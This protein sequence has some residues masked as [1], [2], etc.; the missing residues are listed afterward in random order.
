MLRDRELANWCMCKEIQ[1]V[2]RDMHAT[3]C[4]CGGIDAYGKSKH[5]PFKFKK[6]LKCEEK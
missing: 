1:G 5:R 3:C 2:A 6:I 4:I